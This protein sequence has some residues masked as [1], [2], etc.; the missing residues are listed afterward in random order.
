MNEVDLNELLHVQI[1]SKWKLWQRIIEHR[2]LYWM[3]Y[4]QFMNVWSIPNEIVPQKRVYERDN[5][6][7]ISHS[8][9]HRTMSYL[10]FWTFFLIN[11]RFMFKVKNQI[12]FLIRKENFRCTDWKSNERMWNVVIRTIN[13]MNWE[14]SVFGIFSNVKKNVCKH[15]IDEFQWIIWRARENKRRGVE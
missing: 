10:D 3:W 2:H 8:A 15:T 4:F 5:K 9:N 6:I 14:F 13:S 7:L 11:D 1:I 12:I